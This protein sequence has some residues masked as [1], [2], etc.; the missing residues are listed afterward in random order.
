MHTI[1]HFAWLA[2][3]GILLPSST[4]SAEDAYFMA[5]FGS[6]RPV[7]N[8]AKHAHTFAA[9]V[10]AADDGTGRLRPC[11]MFA[12]SWLAEKLEIHVYRLLPECGANV[13]LHTTLRLALADGARVSVWGPFQIQKELYDRAVVQKARL[14]SGAVRYK[15][16][17]TAYPS[18]RVSNCIHAVADLAAGAPRLRIASPGWGE[19]ASYF[20][21]LQLLPWI[22]APRQTHP[23]V[24]GWLGLGEYELIYRDLDN[25]PTRSV[26]LRAAQSMKHW[27]L[28]RTL[29]E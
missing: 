23:Y 25:N 13:D 14:E 11:E 1:L 21:T 9:F 3:F 4:A 15:A 19:S 12:I 7:V 10:H 8:R 5:V 22:V 29:P 28:T 26:I 27:R 24:A 2:C 6:Q 20:V 17:D 16:V 18:A